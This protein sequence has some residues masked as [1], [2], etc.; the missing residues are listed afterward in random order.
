[1]HRTRGAGSPPRDD[2]VSPER[3]SFEPSPVHLRAI[4]PQRAQPDPAAPGGRHTLPHSLTSLIGRER[5]VAEARALLVEGGV[6]LLTL[7]GPGGVG[8]TRLALRIAEDVAAA[9]ADGVVFVPLAAITDPALM[10]PTIARSLGLRDDPTRSPAAR[11]AAFLEGQ[12]TLLVLDNVEQLQPA[13]SELVGLLTAC[14]TTVA[15]VTSRAPLHIAGEQRFPVFP[16]ALPPATP[17]GDEVQD[18]DLATIAASPA[19]QLFVARARGVDPHFAL[20]TANAASIAAICRRLD[21]LPLAI[22]LAAARIHV[23][24]PG[25]LLVHVG[26]SLSLLTGGPADA[27]DRLRTMRQTIAWSYELLTPQERAGFRRLAVFAGGFTLRAAERVLGA[28][29]PGSPLAVVSEVVRTSPCWALELVSSLVDKSLLQRSAAS[30]DS[31]F[32]MLEPISEFA[33]ERLDAAGE[34]D[35]LSCQHAA[36]YL[37]LAESVASEAF[38]GDPIARLDRLD[39]DHDN[40]RAAFDRLHEAGMAEACLRLACACAPF[41]YDRGHVREGWTRLSD[42][43]ATAGSAP[44]SARG[45]ALIW[46]VELALPLGNRQAATSLAQEAVALWRAQ[47]DPRGLAAALH[48]LATVMEQQEQWMAAQGLFEEELALR[49]TLGAPVPLGIT[50]VR[51][52]GVVFGQG[53]VVRARSMVDEAAAMLCAAGNRRWTGL[54]DWY[55]G[56]F[57][58]SERRVAQAAKSYRDSLCVLSEVEDLVCRFKPIVGLAAIAA[59]RGRPETAARLLGAADRLLEDHGMQL[60]P[61]DRPAYELAARVGRAALGEAEFTAA[62][63]TGRYLT[64]D[65][66]LTE[67]DAIVGATAQRAHAHPAAVSVRTIRHDLTAR[68]RDILRF[69]VAGSS[70][71]EIAAALGI[72]RR[73][74]SNHV[75]TIRDKLDVPSRTAAATAAVRD[76]LV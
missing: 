41:W 55:L 33:R 34:G 23:L 22:E 15:L 72:A 25:E 46:A 50:L 18:S 42:A 64:T 62:A 53:D 59:E 7:T 16:L 5:E 54:A 37:A 2:A 17:S 52:G 35:A 20:D 57:A 51:L 38:P 26:D 47:G 29:P 75:A 43:L 31:R 28:E 67:A 49:R 14:P 19:V 3:S 48:G 45:H 61:F 1:M 66:V 69:L 56:L 11:L 30:C 76:A 32:T 58:A 9:F 21:G 27:P 39:A 68:E 4:V 10:L 74:V 44:T 73:T 71:K 8:K 24:S 36:Y 60:Y 63:H 70:D 6:R 65:E 12:R 13:V 40:L